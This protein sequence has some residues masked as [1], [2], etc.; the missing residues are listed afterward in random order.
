M[1]LI[2]GWISAIHAEVLCGLGIRAA[3]G[4]G[5]LVEEMLEF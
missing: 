5:E 3:M 1:A 4:T 2:L